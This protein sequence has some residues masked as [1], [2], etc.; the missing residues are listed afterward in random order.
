MEGILALYL[1]EAGSPMVA[2]LMEGELLTYFSLNFL[3][4]VF[5]SGVFVPERLPREAFRLSM[6]WCMGSTTYTGFIM[7]SSLPVSSGGLEL[8]NIFMLLFPLLFFALVFC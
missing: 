6:S 3:H 1:L 2:V 7:V 8:L 5:V 4:E